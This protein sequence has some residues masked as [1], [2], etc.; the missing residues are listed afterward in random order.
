MSVASPEFILITFFLAGIFFLLPG[1]GLRQSLYAATSA[2]M[3]IWASDSMSVQ[4]WIS[5][6]VFLA[7]FLGIGF[8][9]ARRLKSELRPEA[10][11]IKALLPSVITIQVLAFM[12]AKKYEGLDFVLPGSWL[13]HSIAIVGL[14]YMLFRQIHFL[15]DVAQEQ[16]EEFELWTYLNYQLN[17][18]ALLAGPI[19][20]YQDFARDWHEFA[21]LKTPGEQLANFQRVFIGIVKLAFLATVVSGWYADSYQALLH[22]I[23][24]DGRFRAGSSLYSS[25][26][27]LVMLYAYPAFVYFNFSGYCDVVIGVSRLLGIHLPE[28]FDRPYVSR[29]MIEFWTRQHMSLS[30]WI[31]DYLFTPM[32]KA[33]VSRW[34]QTALWAPFLCYFVAFVLAG[35]WHGSTANFLIFG[36]LH[37]LGVSTV[38]IWE[39]VIIKRSGRAGLKKYLAVNWIRWVSIFLTLNFVSFAFIFFTPDVGNKLKVLG[40]MVRLTGVS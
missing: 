25:R 31:R 2:G 26:H 5:T 3:F 8:W 7:S 29:N 40:A 19:Q 39:T 23:D 30:F 36:L 21:Q 27:F 32:Y 17:F 6:L 18:L 13:S 37:G 38:K 14:S 4:G 34:S 1:K 35:V 28:N 20:R 22:N 15:V 24:S 10:R 9:A 12:V 33:L 11:P 16:I